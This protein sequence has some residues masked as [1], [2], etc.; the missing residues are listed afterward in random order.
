MDSGMVRVDADRRVSG[1]AF[2]PVGRGH[3]V[4]V[5]FPTGG[6]LVLGQDFGNEQNA[7]DV[8]DAGEETDDVATWR[9]IGKLFKS[10]GIPLEPCW[11][12]NYV[13]GVRPGGAS[14]C[15]GRSPGLRRGALRREC[16]R[17]FRRQVRAQKPCAIIV[18]GSYLPCVLSQDVADAFATWTATSFLRR[19]VCDNA[20]ICD[21]TIGGVTVPVIAS[22]VH[23]SQRGRNV[24]SRRFGGL[25][26]EEAE[27][28]ILR[29]VS[30]A[31]R[32]RRGKNR[33]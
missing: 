4:G 17:F 25:E 29:L 26:G 8:F 21:A 22:I 24:A 12:T 5:P 11:F 27:R 32:E 20:L 3:L 31:L 19:D 18:L 1:R 10:V 2:F 15:A 30:A 23:P 16:A 28:S 7:S 13:M 6:V 9:E 33:G 14:N